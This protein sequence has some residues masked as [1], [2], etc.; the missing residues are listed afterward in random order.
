MIKEFKEFTMRGNLLDMAIG[1]IIGGAFGKIISSLVADIV[2]P[3]IGK[4]IGGID[5]TN[6]YINLSGQTFAS[7]ADAQAA[8][9]PTINYGMFINN[10]LDFIIVALV[11]FFIIRAV[12]KFKKAEE[13][14]QAAPTTK[15]CPFCYSEIA[16]KATRC[17]NCTSQ[18]QQG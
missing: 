10:I 5:F 17:P 2:M 9:A 4:L 7:L 1:I 13:A 15:A 12:N 6:L 11:I 16:I 3:P 8:G 18:L 14:P